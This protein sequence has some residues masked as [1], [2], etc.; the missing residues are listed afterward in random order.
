MM[1][2]RGKGYCWLFPPQAMGIHWHR[3]WRLLTTYE[4]GRGYVLFPSSESRMV[5]ICELTM[6]IRNGKTPNARNR[7][8]GVPPS[9]HW[10]IIQIYKKWIIRSKSSFYRRMHH[11]I[12]LHFKFPWCIKHMIR[13]TKLDLHSF[14]KTSLRKRLGVIRCKSSSLRRENKWA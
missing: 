11:G 10:I 9:T 3:I 2:D 14:R 12:S 5:P 7:N 8:K 1:Q 6:K 13:F 4:L